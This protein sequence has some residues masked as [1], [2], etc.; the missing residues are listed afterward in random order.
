MS[1]TGTI[2]VKMKIGDLVQVVENG[3]YD[4]AEYDLR[5]LTGYIES[6][7]NGL[8]FV[9]IS[10]V[11]NDSSPTEPFGFYGHENEI[12]LVSG[13]QGELFT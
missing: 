7:E 4:P 12:E 10:G 2:H 11:P 5:G 3:G 6:F 8:T 1:A 13:R 9:R